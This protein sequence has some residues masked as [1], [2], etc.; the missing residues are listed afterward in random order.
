MTAPQRPNSRP[1]LRALLITLI[2]VG[3]GLTLLPSAPAAP[4]KTVEAD[5][6]M[7]A[8]MAD[9]SVP[10]CNEA[11]SYINSSGNCVHRPETAG[12][13]PAGATAQCTDGEYSFSQHHAGTCSGH[14]GVAKW[15]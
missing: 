11:T 12:T 6:A 8:A 9:T 1:S 10:S 15:L 4:T 3:S 13:A 5:V 7:V 2:F 14:G